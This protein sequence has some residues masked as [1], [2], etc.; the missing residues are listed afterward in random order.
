M[1]LVTNFG[2]E[3]QKIKKYT[4]VTKTSSIHGEG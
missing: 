3:M 2:H 4:K 1:R